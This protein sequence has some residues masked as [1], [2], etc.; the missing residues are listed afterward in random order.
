M[1]PAHVRLGI[2]EFLLFCH[3]LAQLEFVQPGLQHLHG[4]RTVA[5]LRAI[6]LTLHHDAGGQV[7]DA[8][9]GIRLIDVLATGSA[10]AIGVDTQVG[11]VDFDFDGVVDLRVDEDAGERRM[12][13]VGRVEGA[14]AH[15]AMH[16]AFGTQPAEGILAGYLDGG[17]LDAG[18]FTFGFF[19]HFDLEILVFAI[20][21]VLAQQHGGPILGLCAP[22]PGLDIHEAVHGIGGV[23]EHAAEFEALEQLADGVDVSLDGFQRGFVVVFGGELKEFARIV[24]TLGDPCQGVDNVL[25]AFLLAAELL[26]VLGIVPDV[27]AFEFGIDYM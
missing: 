27:G 4:F 22:G 5:V 9:C 11:R 25:E 20:T 12:A 18:N 3:A 6:I 13:P 24:Q 19:Q 10:C 26:R 21:Q 16:A 2:L 15:Q 1:A 14:L 8:N 17:G 23:G 7:G